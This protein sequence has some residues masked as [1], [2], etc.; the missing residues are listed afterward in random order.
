MSSRPRTQLLVLGMTSIPQ[1]F[2]QMFIAPNATGILWRARACSIQTARRKAIRSPRLH[3]F[4]R[5]HMLPTI[6]K[7]VFIDKAGPLLTSNLLESDTPIIL[8]P[9]FVLWIWLSIACGA[10]NELMEM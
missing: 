3:L 9:I 6:P 1:H 5:N 10:D 7:I 8:H 4:Y 2:Q